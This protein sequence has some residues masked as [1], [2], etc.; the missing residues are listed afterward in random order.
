MKS[1]LFS[2]ALPDWIKALIMA[3]ISAVVTYAY[4]A[5][6]AGTIFNVAF[7]KGMGLAALGAALSY[8]IKNF[9]T[10]SQGNFVK[11]E[12]K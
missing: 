5:I 6:S 8:L 11:A 10:N 1:K 3:V 12:P 2:L 7:L 4:D 9:F